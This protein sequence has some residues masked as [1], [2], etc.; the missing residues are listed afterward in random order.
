[1]KRCWRSSGWILALLAGACTP[2]FARL[3]GVL[4]DVRPDPR[5][6]TPSELGR[7]EVTREGRSSA[8]TQSMTLKQGDTLVTAVDGIGVMELTAGY[9]IILEPGTDLTI[10][11]P[12]IFLRVG[13]IIVKKIRDVRE[14]LTVKTEIGAAAVE[15]TEFVFEA[16]RRGEAQIT[17]LEGRVKVYPRDG[18]RWRDTVWYVAGERGTF[19]TARVGRMP[20]LDARSAAVLRRRI[21]EIEHTV[22]PIVPDV[23]GFREAEARAEL[24]RHGFRVTVTTVITRRAEVGTVTEMQPAPGR[25]VRAGDRIRLDVEEQSVVVPSLLGRPLATVLRLLAGA[26]LRLGDTSS[27]VSADVEDGTV[28]GVQPAAG[29]FV[30]PG[31]AVSITIARRPR[32]ERCRVPSLVGLTERDALAVLQRGKWV[33]GQVSRGVGDRVTSQTPAVGNSVACGSVVSF[34]VGSVIR[35]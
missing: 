26:G 4:V 7:V 14:A 12:S 17:V 25:A 30:R 21:A 28:T 6:A 11:N 3:D 23:R 20:P 32:D 33:A 27:V 19:E 13:R 2:P 9:R 24:E 18:A 22:R 10:E 16:N 15:G 5:L 31:S 35:D 1:M 29:A 8:A 34:M